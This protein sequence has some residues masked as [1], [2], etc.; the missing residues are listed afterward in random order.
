[1]VFPSPSISFPKVI[2]VYC[3]E[4]GMTVFAAIG[5][6]NITIVPSRVICDTDAYFVDAS[7]LESTI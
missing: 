3:S 2:C 6:N 1:M 5:V 4:V 7:N